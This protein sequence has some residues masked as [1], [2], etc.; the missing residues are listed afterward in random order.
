MQEC[1]ELITQIKYLV[2]DGTY[3]YILSGSLLGTIFKDIIS[4]P[5]GYMDIVEMYP[6]DFEEFAAANGVGSKV[7]DALRN[8]FDKKEP[9]DTF[10]H[11]RDGT[12]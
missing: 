4:V 9:V 11:E 10:L 12:V 8:C 2:Q 5:V 6:L 1:R 3:D 7:V